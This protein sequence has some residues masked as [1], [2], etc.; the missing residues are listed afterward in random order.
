MRTNRT[1]SRHGS[2]DT[3]GAGGLPQG[4]QGQIHKALACAFAPPAGLEPATYGLEVDPRPSTP[5]RRVP[6]W[7][8]R[9]DASSS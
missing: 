4:K 9:S 3:V 5:S 7:Q 1:A 2:G 6:F 8:V